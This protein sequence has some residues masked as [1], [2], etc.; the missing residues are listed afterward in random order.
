MWLELDLETKGEDVSV[1]GR[2]SRGERPS[3]H[4]LASEQGFDALQTFANKVGRAVRGGKPLDPAVVEAAQAI[5][6][7][8]LKVRSAWRR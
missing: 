7:E 3:T 4:T 5:H 2:G 1:G 8:V 6:G